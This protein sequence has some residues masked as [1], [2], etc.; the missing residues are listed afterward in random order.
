M[1]DYQSS[2]GSVTTGPITRGFENHDDGAAYDLDLQEQDWAVDFGRKTGQNAEISGEYAVSGN[3]SLKVTYQDDQKDAAASSW[4]L[5][6]ED[7]YYLSYW[8]MFEEDF[9]FDGDDHSGGKLPGL[10]SE[11]LAS[12]GRDVTGDN[13]FTARYMWREDGAAEL[14]LYHMDQPG[15]Y[16]E[17]FEFEDADG[18][19]IKFQ[20]GEW[21]QL[22]QKVTINDGNRA[23][24]EI[25]VWMDGEEVLDLD[26]LRFV[27]DGSG[28][29]RLYF[30]SF[31]GGNDDGWLPERDV[32]AYFDDFIISTDPADVGLGNG[33]AST[34]EVVET[35]DARSPAALD[36]APV[37]APASPV[38]T[39]STP[40]PS[41]EPAPIRPQMAMED[42]DV[43][44]DIVKSWD[45]G[46]KGKIVITNDTDAVID[47]WVLALEMDG[48]EVTK[49]WRGEMDIDDGEVVITGQGRSAEIGV[50]ETVEIG[51]LADGALG[52][53]EWSF[54]LG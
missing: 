24:G 18:E 13:G 33:D 19:P 1:E 10:A 9:D 43:S 6:E 48:F 36:A 23:N 32:S 46:F 16:G 2:D 41:A 30:S 12:G 8:V 51:F 45:D 11:G 31:F 37:L 25:T 7:T 42:P 34:L 3:Q 15:R 27:T 17:S 39:P 4:V 54:D 40:V 28:I 38:A 53:P 35:A 14:Y 21:H 47:D 44:F 50:G 49:L 20:P 52:M 22:T 5:P 29:D 26:G